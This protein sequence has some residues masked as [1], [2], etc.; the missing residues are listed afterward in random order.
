MYASEVG[1]ALYFKNGFNLSHIFFYLY[2][3]F[4]FQFCASLVVCVSAFDMRSEIY[5]AVLTL[6]AALRRL[7]LSNF[8]TGYLFYVINAPFAFC[9]RLSLFAYILYFNSLGHTHFL[10]L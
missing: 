5:P 1:V 8:R 4:R 10:P 3:C 7:V 9:I 2:D 6:F